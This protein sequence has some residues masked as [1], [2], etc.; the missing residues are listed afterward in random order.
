MNLTPRGIRFHPELNHPIYARSSAYGHFG[1][2]AEVDD[3][4]SWE[5]TNLVEALM[6]A[7]NAK[8]AEKSQVFS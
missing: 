6:A 1:R 8:A 7:A 5:W 4:L 2:T 3:S